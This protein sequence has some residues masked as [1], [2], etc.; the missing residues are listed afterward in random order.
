MDAV[1]GPG[2]GRGPATGGTNK[3]GIGLRGSRGSHVSDYRRLVGAPEDPRLANDPSD[4]LPP[5]AVG[6]KVR[7]RARWALP[8]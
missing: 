3:S 6:T 4:V 2:R 8:L 5:R 7:E 1:P